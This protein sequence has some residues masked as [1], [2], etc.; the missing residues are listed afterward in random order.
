MT[1]INPQHLTDTLIK[2]ADE[3]KNPDLYAMAGFIAGMVERAPKYEI[4]DGVANVFLK[5][6]S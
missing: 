1:L 2:V 6:E 5:H 4:P 3:Q